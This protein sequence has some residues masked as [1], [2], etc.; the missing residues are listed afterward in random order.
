MDRKNKKFQLRLKEHE[1]DVLKEIARRKG[2]SA[3]EYVLRYVRK[4]AKEMGIPI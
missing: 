4:D 1:R 2:I 3:A